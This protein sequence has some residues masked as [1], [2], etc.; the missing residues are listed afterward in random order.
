MHFSLAGHVHACCQNGAYSFGD[1]AET[2]LVD[3]WEG[4]LRRTMAE[5]LA[6]GRYPIGCELCE[7]EH[8]RGNRSST[9]AQ[10]FDG[11]S[12]DPTV[13]PRKLEFTLSNRCN[14]AC[15]Q[16]NGD[17]SSTIRAKRE[18]RPP[19]PMPYEDGFFEQLPPFLEHLEVASF[20]GGEP[21]LAPE[22]K[23]VWDLLLACDPIPV[24]RV[25]TNATVWTEAIERYVYDLRMHLAVSIDGATKETYEA[26]RVGAD[27]DRVIDIRDRMLAACNSYGGVF[28][29]NYCLLRANW[30]E[31][32]RF[33]LDAD[34]LGVDANIIPV[35][36]PPEHSLFTLAEDALRRIVD[37]LAEE[38]E[39]L[40]PR[41]G[42]NGSRWDD[43]LRMLEGQLSTA[44]PDTDKTA[45]VVHIRTENRR[46]VER[47]EAEAY[48]RLEAEKREEFLAEQRRRSEP[49]AQEAERDLR[50]WAGREHIEITTEDEVVRSVGAPGWAA[51]LHAEEWVGLGIEA[52]GDVVAARSGVVDFSERRDLSDGDGLIFVNDS[53]L[54]SAG[55]PLRFRTVY[56]PHLGRLM[57]ATPD[58]L[59]L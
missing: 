37:R 4:M 2:P 40:R 22:A 38:G 14:L 3:I 34:E 29:L 16:C 49:I 21:F 53:V 48:A 56:L 32:G 1:V 15:V 8:A 28:H 30:H 6:E 11:Y 13:W 33:L 46:A 50:A 27:F 31:V 7:V 25:T 19:M 54:T 10:E 39:A 12:E 24:V 36:G 17:N 55:G 58:P 5:E 42:R 18:G 23:R 41:L 9:P 59:Q 26:I 47:L 44:G 57:I 52:I 35:F 45:L 51:P 20:L 43:L